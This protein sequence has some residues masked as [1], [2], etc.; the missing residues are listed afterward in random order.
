MEN[1]LIFALFVLAV[2]QIN[3]ADLNCERNEMAMV[4]NTK[5][6]YLGDLTTINSHG[7]EISKSDETVE[8]LDFDGNTKI[9]YLPVKAGEKFPNL[10]VIAAGSCSLKEVSKIN[11]DNMIKL[12]EL[13]L[14][15]NE[16][17]KISSNTFEDLASLEILDLRKNCL[18]FNIF[19]SN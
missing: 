5:S 9:R 3:A 13:L 16:I 17:K 15:S 10:L 4:K 14:Y 12:R 2:L 1:F 8:T 19:S 11:F 18:F 7:Y 6:C